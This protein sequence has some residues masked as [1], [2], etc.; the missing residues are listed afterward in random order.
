MEKL[1]LSKIVLTEEG[2]LIEKRI[3]PR[4]WI[5]VSFHIL[6]NALYLILSLK[7]LLPAKTGWCFQWGMII[8]LWYLQIR[9]QRLTGIAFLYHGRPFKQWDILQ[10]EDTGQFVVVYE[11]KYFPEKHMTQYRVFPLKA[12]KGRFRKRWELWRIKAWVALTLI[13]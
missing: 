5:W 3:V 11:V 2:V 12:E 4:V 1:S 8:L 13:K 6:V 9:T 7:H 10:A